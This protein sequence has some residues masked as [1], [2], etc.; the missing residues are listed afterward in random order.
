LAAVQLLLE[1]G[2]LLRRPV[3]QLV[4]LEPLLVPQPLE[5]LH[6]EWELLRQVLPE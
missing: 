4:P 2:L 5:Q 3:R 1:L 6:L